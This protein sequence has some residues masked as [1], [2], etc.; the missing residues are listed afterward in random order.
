MDEYEEDQNMKVV[1]NLLKNVSVKFCDF[2]K[3]FTYPTDDK[4]IRSKQGNF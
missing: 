2:W 4:Q 1:D 3:S